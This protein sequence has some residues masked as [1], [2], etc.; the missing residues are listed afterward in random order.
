MFETKQQ[1]HNDVFYW[2]VW[3]S[4]DVSGKDKAFQWPLE[5]DFL[6]SLAVVLGQIFRQIVSIRVMT[7]INTNV[8]ASRH[9]KGKE[10]LL[11]VADT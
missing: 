10:V 11:P 8:V 4:R 5:V 7:L 2:F 6:H 9:I 1:S 3:I